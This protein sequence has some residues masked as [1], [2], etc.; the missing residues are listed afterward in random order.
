MRY[1]EY[2]PLFL[3]YDTAEIENINDI[4]ALHGW[5]TLT[6]DDIVHADE[7]P[8]TTAN[9]VINNQNTST[10][11]LESIQHLFQS[12]EINSD[13][14]DTPA[15]S[16]SSSQTIVNEEGLYQDFLDDDVDHES[17]N[18]EETT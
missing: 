14:V 8:N 7:S 1:F 4:A 3:A 2:Y 5:Q 18:E 16:S 15:A 11:I 13:E 9:T 12:N 17:H 6:Q 10:P